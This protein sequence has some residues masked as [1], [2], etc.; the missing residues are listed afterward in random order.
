LSSAD[1]HTHTNFSDGELSP[2]EI[3]NEA[4]KKKIRYLAITDHDT[5][6]GYKKARKVVENFNLDQ[7]TLIPGVEISTTFDG[8]YIH[9]LGYFFD[10]KNKELNEILKL[11]Q[12]RRNEF[13]KY[14]LNRLSK[15]GFKIEWGDILT[16]V[17]GSLG[18][19]HIAYAMKSKGIVKKISDAFDLHLNPLK[20]SYSQR[21]EFD[22]A[23]II[24]LVKNAGGVCSIAHP[25]TVKNAE[26]LI[27][28]LVKKG[29][30]GIE[31]IENKKIYKSD[32]DYIEIGLTKTAGSDFHKNGRNSFLGKNKLTEEEFLSFYN[33][34]KKN[35]N[36]KI[37]WKL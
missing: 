32:E 12:V 25:H 8:S 7:I 14:V 30:V 37:K 31:V 5:L 6:S 33:N 11:L 28:K 29:L 23:E 9:L 35:L 1:L 3:L 15:D 4:I 24:K 26:N 36:G 13:A 27:P 10:D 16:N 21:Y 22:T 19:L 18:R 20:E 17:N 2:N 34:S